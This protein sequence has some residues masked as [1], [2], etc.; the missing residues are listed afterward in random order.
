M[1]I[2]ARLLLFSMR[3]N[4]SLIVVSLH[5]CLEANHVTMTVQSSIQH[6]SRRVLRPRKYF[7]VA[8]FISIG[9]FL[10]GQ[11]YRFALVAR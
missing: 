9:G 2:S 8:F 5:P 7:L 4:L 6:L 10:N 1:S 3:T 11:D